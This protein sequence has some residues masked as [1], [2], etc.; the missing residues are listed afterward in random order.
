MLN[1]PYVRD[2]CRSARWAARSRGRVQRHPEWMLI[3]TAVLE[4]AGHEV[5]FIDGPAEDLEHDD[6]ERA[7]LEFSPDLTVCHTTTPSIYNDIAYARLAKRI[8]DCM[9]CLIGPHVSVLPEDTLARSEGA[10]DIIAR[11]EYDYTLRD[12]AARMDFRD[13]AGISYQ[14]D[15]VTVN[16]P[17]RPPLDV[18]ELPF[19]A[20]RHINPRRYRD[21]GKR[22]PFLTLI[23]G[24]GCFGR[25]TFCRDTPVMYGRKLRLRDPKLVVDEIEYDFS[26][27]PYLKEIMFETDTFTAS[28]DQARQICEEM[29]RRNLKITWSCNVRVDIDLSLLPLMKKAGCRMLMVGFEFGDQ[30]LLDVVRK[31]ITLEQSRAF[32]ARARDLGFTLH[33]CFMVGAP[34]ETVETARKTIDF[35]CSLPL[36][37]VQFSGICVYPGTELYAWA[38][39]R[40]YIVAADWNEWVD[41]NYEQRTLVDYPQLTQPQIDTLID[42]GL[43]R[44]YLRPRQIVRMAFS[45]EIWKDAPRKMYGFKRFLGYLMKKRKTHHA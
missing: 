37:T 7:I 3:A 30:R 8:S 29:M 24:R 6:I 19:P 23:S 5:K 15:G 2:F 33:G 14:R 38:K 18:N 44:F 27:F 9:T 36:D 21:G 20:W 17:D 11:A 35:A 1:P 4:Q 12:I 22:F 28:G 39:T 41:K 16:N 34:G 32:V 26:L 10:V 25:C 13:I 40:G 43:K 31:G 42:D 45:K